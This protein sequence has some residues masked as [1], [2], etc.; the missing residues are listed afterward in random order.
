MS[1]NGE[2]Y[3]SLEHPF[4]FDKDNLPLLFQ[5]NFTA[6]ILDDGRLVKIRFETGEFRIIQ[7]GHDENLNHVFQIKF[8]EGDN[9]TCLFW[10]LLEMEYEGDIKYLC[11]TS[12]DFST[13]NGIDALRQIL[14]EDHISDDILASYPNDGEVQD[15]DNEEENDPALNLDDLFGDVA[16]EA[17]DDDASDDDA[18]DDGELMQV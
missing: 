14:P 2:E 6:E 7:T 16:D 3:G 1:D 15:E 12:Q 18:S 10:G 9:Q 11:V 17:S 5:G 4:L 13:E 8:F